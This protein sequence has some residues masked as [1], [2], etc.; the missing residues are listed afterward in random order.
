M[1]ALSPRSLYTQIVL[2]FLLL[3]LAF[4]AVAV[5]I[6][7]RQFDGF[8]EEL[9]QRL[10]L[11]LAGNLAVEL[12]PA[13]RNG[14]DDAEARRALV[15]V[16]GTNPGRDIYVLD[17]A[18]R[19]LA[20]NTGAAARVA[21]IDIAPLRRIHE[22]GAMLPLRGQDPG[23]ASAR[24]VFSATG[25]QVGDRPGYLYVIL[26]GMPFEA[27]ASM[28]RTS[29][30]ARAI[31]SALLG[32][33]LCTLVIGAVLFAILT[34][35][36][37]R[38]TQEMA[39]T[40]DAQVAALKQA[41]VARRA[42]AANISHD[43]RTP[44]TSLRAH[45][46]RLIASDDR[47]V[48]RE[49][50]DAM[51]RNSAQIEHLADQLAATVELDS[52]ERPAARSEPFD[53]VDLAHDVLAKFAPLAVNAGVALELPP[54]PAPLPLPVRV[55]GDIALIE[56]ALSN[57]LDNALQNTPAGGRV[58]LAIGLEGER[59]LVS[60]ADTGPGIA[61]DEIGQVTQRFYRTRASRAAGR[62]GSGLGLSIAR[63]IMELHDGAL[64]IDS[65]PGGGTTIT[66]ALPRPAH[67]GQAA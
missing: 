59:V 64:T 29:Y 20:S 17:A 67:S 4:T 54:A 36:F 31:G 15:R 16:S 37:R 8:L 1:N 49:S 46:D 47:A 25:L 39:A 60:V 50:L 19:V 18:G 9:E 5:M 13:L 21:R 3:L 35:R 28:L 26:R 2:L 48:Q 55:Q 53:M 44:L 62:R 43:F 58:R 32:A 40:I 23:D 22:P 45:V 51:L 52:V 41:D 65:P 57:V 7:S 61:Q 34:R 63:E 24:K 12:G 30:I 66:L 11:G 33:L 56:R 10:N 14:A 42:L 27:A 6:A 38:L